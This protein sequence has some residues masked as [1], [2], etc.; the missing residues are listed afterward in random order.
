[1]ECDLGYPEELHDLHNDYPMAPERRCVKA[2]MLSPYTEAVYRKTYDKPE[3]KAV[4]DE[5]SEK[6]ILSL[7]DKKKYVVHIRM[8]HFYLEHGM[9]LQEIH[10][11]I[12]FKQ[13]K[14]LE[15]YINFNTQKRKEPTTDFE[16]DFFKLM[17]NAPYGKTMESV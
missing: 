7:S 8:L 11:V 1:M 4:P 5:K 17:N 10:R 2:D 12:K 6:L 15:P 14:W 13:S 3:D 9:V 16:K